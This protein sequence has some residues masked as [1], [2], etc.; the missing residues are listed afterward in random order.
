MTKQQKFETNQDKDFVRAM[1]IMR[2]GSPKVDA[3]VRSAKVVTDMYADCFRVSDDINDMTN[4]ML[5]AQVIDRI[6]EQLKPLDYI[7]RIPSSTEEEKQLLRDAHSQILDESGFI[8][9]LRDDPRGFLSQAQTGNT[10][11]HFG[12][13]DSDLTPI[14]FRCLSMSQVFFP[15][16][17]TQLR[18]K[19]GD[20][21][22]NEAFVIFEYP[23]DEIDERYPEAKGKYLWGDLPE[24]QGQDAYQNA[25]DNVD[26]D[27]EQITQ[28]GIYY[29]AIKKIKKVFIG[30]T[31]YEADKETKKDWKYIL[32]GK[33]YI[34][35]LHFKGK[36]LL[37]EMYA[38]GFGQQH[39]K[40]AREDQ[41]RRNMA[42]RHIE[43]NI[44]PTRGIQMEESKYGVFLSQMYEAA[45]LRRDGEDPIVR[46]DPGTSTTIETFKS[47]PL[48]GEF[49][50]AN[51]DTTEQVK[52]N[53]IALQDIDRPATQTATQTL[54]E[55]SARIRP[56]V[57]MQETNATEYQFAYRIIIDFMRR[58]IKPTNDTPVVT[59]VKAKVTETDAMRRG[60]PTERIGEEVR[61][62][63]IT[64]GDISVLLKEKKKIIV[65][66]DSRSG[67]WE[68]DAFVMSKVGMGAQFAAGTQAETKWRQKGLMALGEDTLAQELK[69]IP[70]E[71]NGGN[72]ANPAGQNAGLLKAA[73]P[74]QGLLQ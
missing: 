55:E 73:N 54:A 66:E 12:A 46:L 38:M 56:A 7:F 41:R 60:L 10:I 52:R 68:T 1:D 30:R 49:E 65:Q 36:S 15:T 3:F 57:S 48:T 34:P 33:S 35:L 6:V 11:M 58:F 50:R 59:N 32:D 44:Y 51:N 29:N 5:L 61:V 19:N 70:D 31:G 74:G 18:S 69:P 62:E 24:V 42:F 63:G 17:A 40:L 39:A 27:R 26:R 71:Q 14:Y 9:C 64:L 8:S 13:E 72:A 28:V 4:P 21:D 22:A 2:Y 25:N 47:D 67:A 16:S 43:N 23:S 20:N 53:G 45:Q 37:G